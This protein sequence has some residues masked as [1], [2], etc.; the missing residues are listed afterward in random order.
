MGMRIPMKMGLFHGN[1]MAMG[2]AF[3]PMGM[4]IMIRK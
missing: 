1:S 4:G 2:A 3:G